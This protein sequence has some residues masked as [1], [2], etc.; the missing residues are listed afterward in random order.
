MN[1]SINLIAAV[2]VMLPVSAA[3]AADND[4]M[5][6]Q[7]HQRS[8]KEYSKL[9]TNKD[10]KVSQAEAAVDATIVWAAADTDGDGYIDVE[11]WAVIP[12]DASQQNDSK[13]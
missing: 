11:E 5:Q 6:K 8:S 1:Q 12:A 7:D 4:K 3:M 13:R 10:G 9:D 2:V